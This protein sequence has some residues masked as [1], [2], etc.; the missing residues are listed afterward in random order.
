MWVYLTNMHYLQNNQITMLT[1]LNCPE[2]NALA[3]AQYNKGT[4]CWKK[5]MYEYVVE[6]MQK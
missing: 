4:G 2:N 5:Q 3:T 6:H 1:H